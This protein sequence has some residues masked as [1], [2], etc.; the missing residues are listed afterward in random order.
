MSV[1]IASFLIHSI[2][3]LIV[4]DDVT[5]NSSILISGFS[6]DNSQIFVDTSIGSDCLT[7][8]QTFM[9]LNILVVLRWILN[10]G[11]IEMDAIVCAGAIV[12]AL[13][14]IRVQT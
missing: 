9:N 12:D 3:D 6:S 8:A 7:M 1:N 2:N 4:P 14:F 11:L 5:T 10:V 13:T